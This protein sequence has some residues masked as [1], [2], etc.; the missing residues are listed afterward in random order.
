MGFDHSLKHLVC[1][2]TLNSRDTTVCGL[3]Y[4][5]IYIYI[6]IC[7]LWLIISY[8]TWPYLR[9]YNS[10]NSGN[11]VHCIFSTSPRR[12]GRNAM[13]TSKGNKSSLN[14]S[15]SFW[16]I[17]SP[18]LKNPIGGARGVMVIVIGNGHGNATSNPGRDW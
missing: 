4:I 2:A 11:H 1:L 12:A 8:E 18:R 13:F 17:D 3:L 5:Y 10:Y 7:R 16:W 9:L 14:C 15:F 6:Y